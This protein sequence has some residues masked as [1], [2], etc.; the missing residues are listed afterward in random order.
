MK[1][2]F[3]LVFVTFVSGLLLAA[4]G[5]FHMRDI[6]SAEDE[7]LQPIRQDIPDE[8]NAFS[9]W[10]RA[11]EK[12]YWPESEDVSGMALGEHWDEELATRILER[13]EEALDLLEQALARGRC[14][15]PVSDYM[16]EDIPS[17]LPL[18]RSAVL[19]LVRARA[20][21]N[22]G[23]E[24][25]AFEEAMKVVRLGQMLEGLGGSLVHYFCGSLA[26]EMALGQLRGFAATTHVEA[27]VLKKYVDEL[28]AYTADTNGLVNAL[29]IEYQREAA[30]LEKIQAGGPIMED[31]TLPGLLFQ[32]SGRRPIQFKL[33]KTKRI[34]A[35]VYRYW[36]RSVSRLY[37]DVGSGALPDSPLPEGPWAPV[38]LLLSGNATGI[39][40]TIT[41]PTWVHVCYRK[42]Y[43]NVLVA[44]TRLLL[45][46]K[47]YELRTGDLP[48]SLQ[49]LVPDCIDAVPLD[50][51][52]DLPMRYSPE[53]M[54][55]YSVGTDLGD[56]G[57]SNEEDGK[58]DM[59][60]PTFRIDFRT[61]EKQRET[62]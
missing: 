15:V 53:K 1:K 8:E 44:A 62:E 52:D 24:S 39:I 37:V 47:A 20:L 23:D 19:L 28:R 30:T 11:A 17:L 22:A 45:A 16:A 14:Q 59:S 2:L 25:Q 54:I 56:S 38:T 32:R 60:E 46:M 50:D 13:N 57:G 33:N 5:Y 41:M 9:Y 10:T 55:I 18:V 27:R 29:R 31:Q 42:S 48:Q 26:K 4:A 3:C 35:E 21:F 61:G 12:L 34:Y 51:F 7:D 40:V 6:P 36:I 58:R 43:E 49:E